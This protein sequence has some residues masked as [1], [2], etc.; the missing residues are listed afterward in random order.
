MIGNRLGRGRVTQMRIDYFDIIR[1]TQPR[2]SSL[3]L[4]SF[5]E[6]ISEKKNYRLLKRGRSV[7]RKE[8][9]KVERGI[10]KKRRREREKDKD[11]E[12]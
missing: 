4:I 2:L 1:Y 5:F 10:Q 6:R 3:N 11:R 9:I 12:R 8:K 7:E